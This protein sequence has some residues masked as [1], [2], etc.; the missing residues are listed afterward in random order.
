MYWELWYTPTVFSLYQKT[1]NTW[2]RPINL[3]VKSLI[4]LVWS[5]STTSLYPRQHPISLPCNVH[6]WHLQ[7]VKQFATQIW[8]LS[9]DP[10]MSDSTRYHAN[11]HLGI[12]A[13]V[14]A[15]ESFALSF[16]DLSQL[17]VVHFWIQLFEMGDLVRQSLWQR[18]CQK[19]EVTARGDFLLGFGCCWHLVPTQ[20]L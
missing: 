20:D 18:W 10:S 7:I 5:T 13:H 16:C 19:I 3:Q 11:M 1:P 6:R 12:L 14:R 4:V 9:F 17:L 15:L 2:H 8:D